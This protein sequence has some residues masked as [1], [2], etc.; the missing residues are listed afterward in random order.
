MSKKY[1]SHHQIYLK[2][3]INELKLSDINI[4]G[5]NLQNGKTQGL[6]I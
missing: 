1:I 6:K 4:K 5:P 2:N 3:M